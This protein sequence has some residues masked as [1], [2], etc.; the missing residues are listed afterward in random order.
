VLGDRKYGKKK[1]NDH[2][3]LKYGL[4]RLFLHAY[5]LEF[6]HPITKKSI[7]ITCPLPDDLQN[8]LNNLNKEANQIYKELPYL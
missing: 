3:L 8:V 1:Y 2:Y 4:E 7:S 5:Y 6:E